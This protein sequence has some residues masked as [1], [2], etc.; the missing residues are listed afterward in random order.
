VYIILYIISRLLYT[1]RA[2]VL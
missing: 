2:E 1:K